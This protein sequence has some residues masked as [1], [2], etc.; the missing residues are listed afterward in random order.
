MSK[1]LTIDI[2][3]VKRQNID[4]IK[5]LQDE[6]QIDAN[7]FLKK[8]FVSD[9]SPVPVIKTTKE[10]LNIDGIYKDYLNSLKASGKASKTI[11]KYGSEIK[12]YLAY[13]KDKKIDLYSVLKK[14]IDEYLSFQC[15]IRK[16]GTNSFSKVI[17]IIKSFYKYLYKNELIAKD[18]N[19]D[20]E[21]PRV[22]EAIVEVLSSNDIAKIEHYLNSRKENYFAENTR[23]YLIM[24]LGIY[25]GL[26]KAEMVN[27]NW[28]EINTQECIIK[29]LNSKGGKNRMLKFND[30]VKNLL[31]EYRKKTGNYK[32]AVIRGNFGKRITS[33]SLQNAVR[34]IYKGS[35]VLRKNL[36]IHSL[37]HT[38]ATKHVEANTN[39]H[40]LK[41][42][43]GHS[44]LNTT[45]AYIHR[46][47]EYVEN[48]ILM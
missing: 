30:K 1:L 17:I 24:Y 4:I 38:F 18:I 11:D 16:L 28:E 44:D 37:R 5:N 7:A 2:E 42:L 43:L 6:A 39:T 46:L 14:D 33:C 47:T 3:E 8:Y 41:N 12:R 35:G 23:D 45:D 31:I 25:C 19:K 20:L 21:A 36:T 34:N 29:I 13:L 40:T 15:K 10:S 48:N 32:G 27:L 9:F 22:P 26:R